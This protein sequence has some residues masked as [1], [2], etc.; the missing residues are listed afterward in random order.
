MAVIAV[1]DIQWVEGKDAAEYSNLAGWQGVPDL[2]REMCVVQVHTAWAWRSDWQVP[3][4][5]SLD[6]PE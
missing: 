1:T 4:Q 3:S 2:V 6:T 5:G